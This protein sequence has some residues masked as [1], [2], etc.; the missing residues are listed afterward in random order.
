[1]FLLSNLGVYSIV[2]FWNYRIDLYQKKKLLQ[3]Y[4]YLPAVQFLSFISL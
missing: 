3:F 4:K 1:M 2:Q